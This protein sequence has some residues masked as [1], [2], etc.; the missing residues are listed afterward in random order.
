MAHATIKGKNFIWW[1]FSQLEEKDF[2]LLE[3]EFQFHPL[4]FDDMRDDGELAKVDVYKYYLFGVVNVPH[5]D[6][7]TKILR[8]KN[9]AVFIGK[10]YVVTATR[11][12]IDAVER[13][14]ARASRSSGMRRDALGKS[15]GYFLYKLLDYVFRDA[16][17]VLRELV[18]ESEHVESLVYDRHTRVTTK[19]LG[20][21][22]RNV[23]QM[24]QMIEPQRS[25]VLHYVSAG[26]AFIKKDLALYF[27]DVQ[28]TLENMSV[29]LDNLKHIVDGLFDVNEA[30]LSHRTNE[31]IRILTIIS[32]VLMPP[33]LITG[34][35]GMNISNLPF[36]DSILTVS[37]VILLSIAS[38]WLLI[39]YIDRR[40]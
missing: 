28:D 11:K 23:L 31:I 32:V 17:V 14:F 2:L 19:R 33:T 37:G 35:Y 5:F 6:A 26:K 36:G 38:F 9:L 4:D 13:F 12:P 39:T 7:Q 40:R 25:L 34:Y 16:K 27:D 29:V 22:R 15:T 1:H 30:F 10:D 21:L 3:K 18:R 24:R 8:K 20:I